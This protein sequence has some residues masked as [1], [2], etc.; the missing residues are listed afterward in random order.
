MCDN[1]SDDELIKEACETK[2]KI[3][4]ELSSTIIDSKLLGNIE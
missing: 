1:K 2:F 3:Y 4:G